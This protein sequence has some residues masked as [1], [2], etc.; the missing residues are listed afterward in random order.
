MFYELKL[1]RFISVQVAPDLTPSE[2][3]GL[4]PKQNAFVEF[5]SKLPA[6]SSIKWLVCIGEKT[7][8]D[9]ITKHFYKTSIRESTNHIVNNQQ[10]IPQTIDQ[11]Q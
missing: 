10:T 7:T 4:K 8:I 9:K 11:Q 3:L 2:R 1:K 6:D 5:N